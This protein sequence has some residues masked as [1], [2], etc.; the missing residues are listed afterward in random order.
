[1]SAFIPLLLLGCVPPPALCS[2]TGNGVGECAPLLELP[3]SNG[4]A[5]SLADQLN[6]VVLVQFAASW[7]G[8]CQAT[9]P[10]D[11]ALHT[12]YSGDGFMKVTVLKGDA[13]FESADQSDAQEWKD[14]FELTH[15]VLYDEDK[16]AWDTW[17]RD[18]SSI[19]QLFLV[20][21]KGAIRWRK[22]GL[23]PEGALIEKIEESLR[24]LQ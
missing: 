16:T 6:R 7:C 8:V 22:I 3:R 12:S 9:A 5:W 13:D 14:F 20:D 24:H 2:E 11:Q 17:R 10:V 19:P 1:M 15:P 18:S 4:E 21:G 23:V